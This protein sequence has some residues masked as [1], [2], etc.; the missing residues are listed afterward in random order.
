[1]PQSAA[2][3]AACRAYIEA[4]GP[5]A[6]RTCSRWV[7]GPWSEESENQQTDS[8]TMSKPVRYSLGCRPAGMEILITAAAASTGGH[9][10]RSA[11]SARVLRHEPT[12]GMK[13]LA[14]LVAKI[15]VAPNLAQEAVALLRSRFI[16][17]EPA[18][19]PREV[20]RDPGR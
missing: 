3:E 14:N 8:E 15:G 2:S 1:M 9:V 7:G 4:D 18:E 19:L 6:A 5:S 17:V 11:A 20:C 10:R 16:V 13:Q 12:I